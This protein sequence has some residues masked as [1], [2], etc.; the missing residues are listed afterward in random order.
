MS[1]F[2]YRIFDHLGQNKRS[3]QTTLVYTCVSSIGG[4]PFFLHHVSLAQKKVKAQCSHRVLHL[5][6]GQS[7]TWSI[8]CILT[9]MTFGLLTLGI[10]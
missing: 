7:Y 4:A 10:K 1:V 2:L 3:S 6:T 5:G 8:S 9:P